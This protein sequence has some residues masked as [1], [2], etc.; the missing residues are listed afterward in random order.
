SGL[1][2]ADGRLYVPRPPY[3]QHE[4]KLFCL[5]IASGGLLWTGDIGG[6]YVWDRESPI[7]IGGKVV[8]GSSRKGTPPGTVVQAWDAATGKPAW[9]VELNVSGNKAG[10]IAGATDGK[11]LY[12]SAGAGAWQ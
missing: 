12:Y 3:G 10:A 5:D 7:A 11:T 6:R 4:G 2:A 9:E 1:L 8:F